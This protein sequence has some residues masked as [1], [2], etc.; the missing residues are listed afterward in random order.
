M[1]ELIK[2]GYGDFLGGQDASK[3]PDR[4]AE[5]AYA[6]GINISVKR[7]SVQP[8]WG[9]DRKTVTYPEGFVLDVFRRP[10]TY[11][12]IFESGKF[13]ALCPFFIGTL[14]YLII[15]VAG[16]IF[17]WN[18]DTRAFTIIDIDDGSRLNARA[19]RINWS[20]AGSSLILYDFPAYPVIVEGLT[21]RRANPANMEIP[22]STI[23]AFNQNRLFVANNGNE[24][25]GG[26]PV[27]SIAT[28]NAPITFEEIFTI[29]SPYFGQLFKTPT[30]DHNDP[31]TFMG[32]LP[33]TDTSTGIGPLVIGT[34]RAIY[35]FNTQ[36]SRDTWDQG[37]FGSV[38]VYNAGIVGPRAWCSVNSD[39]FFISSD[40]FARS[41]SMSRD[42]QHK[43]SKV[44]ISREVENWFKYWDKSLTPIAFISYFK[45][46]IFFGVNPY[47][48]Q[49][50]DYATGLPISDYAHGGFAVLALDNLTSFGEVA[51]PNWE[52]L[53]TG[54]H[55]MDMCT[56]GDRAYV[57]SKDGEVNRIYELNS[58]INH[59]TAD[60]H[61]RL[62]RSRVY[63]REHDF[64]DPHQNKE[65]H[66][67][68]FNF[69]TIEGDFSIFIK[70]K[71]SHWANFLDWTSFTHDAPWRTCSIPQKCL[72]RGFAPHHIRDFI[73]G[74][75]SKD[76]CSTVTNEPLKTFRKVQIELTISGKY[77]EIHEYLIRAMPKALS[78]LQT[79]CEHFPA[80][81]ICN[82]C[83]DDWDTEDFE[84]C[85]VLRT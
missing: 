5:N 1:A 24:F 27:G 62:V 68:T 46:K 12:E 57:I 50:K 18:P 28:P 26:D 49:A 15:V 25:T 37:Q 11:K 38:T 7:G 80:V 16:T 47:R 13:Q 43:W 23:G 58:E 48:M 33:L 78:D 81:T 39:A 20:A 65:L 40:G 10:R 30:S 69:D 35:T 79:I 54:V 66:S 14:Q 6:A 3:I 59:D 74:A 60:E 77:W 72:I 42:E 29:G 34:N 55:P 4:I 52:G 31:I 73:L 75:P 71:P 22:V 19:Q 2:D 41:L 67:I 36:N 76:I 32:F 82:E 8:R 45:N 17:L 70:Y 44:P 56:L 85:Q 83:N 9:F 84:G 64:K 51:K 53:W 21:A 61:V 63:T